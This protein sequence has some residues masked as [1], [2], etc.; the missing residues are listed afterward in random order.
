MGK[1]SHMC[2][3]KYSPYMVVKL[4]YSS[5]SYNQDNSGLEIV[6]ILRIQI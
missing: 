6:W 3:I 4:L 2:K 1:Y 5:Y